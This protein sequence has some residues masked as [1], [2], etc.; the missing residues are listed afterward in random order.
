[1]ALHLRSY[2][3]DNVSISQT[4]LRACCQSLFISRVYKWFFKTNFEHIICIEAALCSIE[5]SEKNSKYF[6]HSQ[7]RSRVVSSRKVLLGIDI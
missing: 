6:W 4:V 3:I 7:T 1:M 5:V 2:G